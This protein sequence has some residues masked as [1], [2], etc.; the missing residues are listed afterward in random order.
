MRRCVRWG[1]RLQHR[2][3][4]YCVSIVASHLEKNK[5]H[6]SE[7]VLYLYDIPLLPPI[8]ARNNGHLLV[9]YEQH[10]LAVANRISE[11]NLVALKGVDPRQS[12]WHVCV[13]CVQHAAT[14]VYEYRESRDEERQ[15]LIGGQRA[16][17]DGPWR[18]CGGRLLTRIDL[19][20]ML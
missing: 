15:L 17:V 11:F 18:R 9:L 2:R 3:P 13:K 5:R 6:L 1:G 14:L 4:V 12:L 10:I 16:R 8:I 19:A 7:R 20:P